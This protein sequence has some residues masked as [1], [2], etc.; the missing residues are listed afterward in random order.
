[1]TIKTHNGGTLEAASVRYI[2][3]NDRRNGSFSVVANHRN[4]NAVLLVTRDRA[5]AEKTALM[6]SAAL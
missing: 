2:A 1:M 3:V 5:E 6:L 4:G